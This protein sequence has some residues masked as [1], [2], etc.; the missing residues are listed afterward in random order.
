[1][2]VDFVMLYVPTRES[3]KFTPYVMFNSAF[4][5]LCIDNPPAFFF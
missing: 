5:S 3:G 1:M 4:M 2:K